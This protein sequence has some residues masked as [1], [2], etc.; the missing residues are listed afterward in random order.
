MEFLWEW[1]QQKKDKKE[2]IDNMSGQLIKWVK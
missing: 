2:N 1:N